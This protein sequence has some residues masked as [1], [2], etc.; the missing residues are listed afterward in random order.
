MAKTT[1]KCINIVL[2]SLAL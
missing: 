2:G 1:L